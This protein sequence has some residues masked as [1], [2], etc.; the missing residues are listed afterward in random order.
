MAGKV[1]IVDHYGGV[2]GAEFSLVALLEGTPGGP[3]YWTAAFPSEGPIV[4]RLRE[5][6]FEVHVVRAE[7]WRWWIDPV[8]T[9]GKFILTFPLQVISLARWMAFF[10]RT[11]PRLVHFNINRLVEPILAAGILGI[12]SVMHFRDIPSLMEARFVLGNRAFY[13]L[14]RRAR[15]WI[16]NSAATRADIEPR[17]GGCVRTIPNGIDLEEFDLRATE[18]EPLP[19]LPEGKPV[20]AM[21]SLLVPWKNHRLL[22]EVA[23]ALKARGLD[24]VILA[25][26]DGEAA[27]RARLLDRAREMGV[28]DVVRFVGHVK[29]VPALL[30]RVDVLIHPTER[31]SFGRVFLEAMAARRPVV[32]ARGGGASEV[33]VHDVTGILVPAGNATAMANAL[34]RLFGDRDTRTEMGAAGRR[35]VE[36]LFTIRRHVDQVL[37]VHREVLADA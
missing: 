16:A 1:M 22:L 21:V 27:F 13:W 12:P 36:E 4:D 34:Q 24:F 30:S 20:A 37:A 29:N 33:V 26:G 32:A 35:R 25:A 11:A 2:G 31:E 28:D 6:G 18:G 14:M 10:R 7:G 23:L 15:V 9:R 5:G 19:D 8:A 3:A 17:S